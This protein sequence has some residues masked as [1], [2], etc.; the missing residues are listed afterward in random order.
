MRDELAQLGVGLLRQHEVVER[1]RRRDERGQPL[2]RVLG[3]AARGVPDDPP[4]EPGPCQA[5][6]EPGAG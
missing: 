6:V 2:E 4:I 1:E 5:R 3:L